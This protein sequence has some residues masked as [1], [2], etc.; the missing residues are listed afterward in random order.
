M[1]QTRLYFTTG[2]IESVSIFAALEAA[3]EE[4]GLPIA[5]LE[6]DEDKDI[7]EV[8]LYADGDVDAVET[9]LKDIL[10]GL[11]LSKPIE[12]EPLPD[13]DW[14]AHSLEELKPVRA[15]RFFVHG[16]HD[17][18]KRHSGELAIEIE[19]GLAFGTGHHGTTAGCLE[20]LERVVRREH[21]RNALDLGTGSAVLAIAVAKLAHIPVLATDI[22]PVAVRV[23][24][25][26]ARLNHVKALVETATAP[27]F[28]HPI[29]GKRAPFDLIV[30]NI[31]ARPLMRLA[32][33]MAHHIALGG[34]IVLSGIL[35]RQRDA[36]ISAY[37]GQNFRHVR[38]L[39]REGWVTIHLKH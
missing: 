29:F 7:H 3:F 21:P 24:A 13:I 20:M 36:V 17:R 32:P 31:L 28:H 16:A 27:G 33:Q 8:S 37:V 39:H 34:S 38:T 14:V 15:G 30:A 1:T 5:V 4:E 19:A 35:E 6:V 26:N 2:K 22:D 25:A 18:R 11:S 12:R 23:A 10:A 9:R